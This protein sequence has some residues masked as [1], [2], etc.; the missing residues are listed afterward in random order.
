MGSV[1]TTF[2]VGMLSGRA[3]LAG[4]V[5]QDSGIPAPSRPA[6]QAHRLPSPRRVRRCDARTLQ[7]VLQPLSTTGGGR[8]H[9]N[10]LFVQFLLIKSEPQGSAAPTRA[11][12][13]QHA[14]SFWESWGSSWAARAG[15]RRAAPSSAGG[16]GAGL[17]SRS[18]L[19]QPRGL[20]LSIYFW[21]E[22]RGP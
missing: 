5:S 1:W 6:Q 14:G 12:K 4:I 8:I 18:P 21:S 9:V 10:L 19:T 17:H 3:A 11:W 7:P 20:Y 15:Q 16:E 2:K 13:V 22:R